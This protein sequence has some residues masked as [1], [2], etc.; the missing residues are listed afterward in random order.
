MKIGALK[1][2][3][4]T[5]E[6]VNFLETCEKDRSPD[7]DETSRVCEVAK[8]CTVSPLLTMTQV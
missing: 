2:D 5:V 1:C 8:S 6:K 3:G 4:T 7:F